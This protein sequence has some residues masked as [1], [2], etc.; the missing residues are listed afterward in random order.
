M[1]VSYTHLDVYKRQ[2]INGSQDNNSM[3]VVNP[4]VTR[5]RGRPPS[6]VKAERKLGTTLQRSQSDMTFPKPAIPNSSISTKQLPYIQRTATSVGDDDNKRVELQAQQLQVDEQQRYS[7]EFKEISLDDG[8]SSDI[9]KDQDDHETGNTLKLQQQRQPLNTKLELS[10]TPSSPSLPTSPNDLAQANGY[11]QHHYGSNIGTS[12]ILSTIPPYSAQGRPSTADINDKVNK[13]LSKLVDYFISNDMRLNKQVPPELLEP[14]PNSAPFIDAPIDPEQHSAFHW[15]CSMGILPIVETLFSAGTNIRTTN[16]HGQTP[17]MR[18][19]MFHNSYTRRSFPRI[20]QLLHETVFDVDNDLQTV[21]HHIVK[22]KS[23][24]PSAIYYLDTVL[25]KIKD[26]SPQY[27]VEMLLNAQDNNGDTALHIAARNGDKLFFDTLL[28][29]GALNTIRNKKGLTPNEIMNEH[30]QTQQNEQ[31][32]SN[33][34]DK[35]RLSNGVTKSP[36]T[37]SPVISDY[38]MYPSQAAT[39]MS[40]GIPNIVNMMKQMAESYNDVLQNSESNEKIL[41]KKLKTISRA[42]ESV[43]SKNIELINGKSEDELTPYI[44]SK[45]QEID[46]LKKEVTFFRRE[47]KNK[48]ELRQSARL[49][50]YVELERTGEGALIDADNVEN[51]TNKRLQL[52][53]ELTLLQMKRRKER[54]EMILNF[55]NDNAKIHKYRRM[56]SEATELG[57]DEVDNCLEVILQNLV[58]IS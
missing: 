50:K 21:I 1:A 12:P 44:D 3:T 47:M 39:R 42:I 58:N 53:T 14:P 45:I 6:T 55:F 8:L 31:G 40:R 48:I 35:D 29:N 52:A 19:A 10:S 56:I 28:N 43:S 20:F 36:L 27:G 7:T 46:D 41:L 49:K 32:G 51:D 30:Y 15:A 57:T 25:S 2:T 16:S 9:E 5:R 54:I 34:N 37:P 22:R 24:T 17:L 4:V 26:F 38:L 23:S 11:D 33:E 18:S 13:Y